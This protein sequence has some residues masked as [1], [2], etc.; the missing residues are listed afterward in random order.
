M[1]DYD[2]KRGHYG[3][4]EGGK[5]EALM[6]ELFGPVRKSGDVLITSGGALKEM[7]VVV[8]SKSSLSIETVMDMG[9]DNQTASNTIAKYNEFLLRA[10]G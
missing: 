1:Q 8:K 7:R 5:L 9:V 10:T 6:K 4:I 3:N 2:I